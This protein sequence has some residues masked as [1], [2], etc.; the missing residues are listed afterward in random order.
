MLHQFEKSK[1]ALGEEAELGLK[2]YFLNAQGEVIHE[3]AYCSQKMLPMASTKKIA[4]ALFVLFKVYKENNLELDQRVDIENH[5]FSPGRPTNTLDRFFFIPWITT[6]K[7]TI[8][9]LL[10]YMLTESDNTSTDVLLNLVG[11]TKKINAFINHLDLNGFNLSYSSKELL[12]EYF[13][14][15]QSKS[16]SNIFKTIYEFIWGYSFRITENSMVQS[17]TDSCTPEMMANLLKL[18]IEKQ[19]VEWI[20]QAKEFIFSTMNRCLTGDR[21]IKAGASILAPHTFGSK[22]GAIGG[23]RNDTAYIEFDDQ[24][25]AIIS[26]HTCKSKEPLRR[27]DEVIASLAAKIL[28]EYCGPY[29]KNKYNLEN[30]SYADSKYVFRH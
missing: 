14:L 21:V 26:I 30:K 9:E 29:L 20:S 4:I 10:T 25:K 3:D 1:S 11:G 2:F 17:E 28:E 16:I 27:R 18:L 13:S 24:N 23:I 8:R 19:E 5:D 15:S 7:R 12:S 6:E 22:Q